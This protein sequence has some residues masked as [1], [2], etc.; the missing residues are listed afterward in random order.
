MV[1]DELKE[2]LLEADINARSYVENTE[3]YFKLKGFKALMKGITYMA[4]V[5]FIGALALLALLMLS[6]AGSLGLG[7][8]LDNTI[9]G[10]LIVGLIY[11]LIAIIVYVFRDRINKPLLRIFS[12]YYFDKI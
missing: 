12:E 9:Y 10:F 2:N 5:V 7:Q 8:L 4:R 6:L 1:F 11:V 3:E